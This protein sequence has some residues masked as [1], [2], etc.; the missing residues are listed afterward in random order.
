MP[1]NDTSD[2]RDTEYEAEELR[3]SKQDEDRRKATSSCPRKCCESVKAKLRLLDASRGLIVAVVLM[4][5]V[6]AVAIV[7]AN[8]YNN[9]VADIQAHF[10]D[11]EAAA[12]IER[13]SFFVKLE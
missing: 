2:E 9:I 4:T 6:F 5:C 11:T 10:N 7:F 3:L 13:C 8:R 12:E 1:Q